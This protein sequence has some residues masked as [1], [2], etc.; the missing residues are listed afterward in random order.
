MN[1]Y[2]PYSIIAG[3]LQVYFRANSTG[4]SFTINVV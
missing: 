3:Y 4:T 2:K 1:T